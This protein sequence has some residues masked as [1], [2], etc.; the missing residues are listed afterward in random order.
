MSQG[1]TH[2]PNKK[3]RKRTTKPRKSTENKRILTTILAAITLQSYALNL[4]DGSVAK[5]IQDKLYNHS[6]ILCW[7][8]GEWLNSLKMPYVLSEEMKKELLSKSDKEWFDET[9]K[10]NADEALKEQ[11]ALG[12]KYLFGIGTRQNILPRWRH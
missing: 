5:Q 8:E 1:H 2:K 10:D 12:V 7:D 4:P 3:D 9:F 6:F 11:S